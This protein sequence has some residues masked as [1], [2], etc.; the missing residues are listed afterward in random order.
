MATINAVLHCRLNPIL[1]DVD[2]TSYTIDTEPIYAL[3]IQPNVKAIIPVH[4]FGLAA[5]MGA[6]RDVA[7]DC[8]LRVIEDACEALGATYDGVPVG[9]L[10]DVSCFSFYM[11]HHITAGVGGMAITDDPQYARKMRSLI[12]HGWERKAAPIDMKEFDFDE[13]RKRYHFASIG[14][15]SRPTEFEAAI[16]LPQL[17]DLTINLVIRT[18]NAIHLTTNLTQFKDKLQLPYFPH[19]RI[20]SCMMYPIILRDGDKWELIRHLESNGIET[21]EMLPLTNQPCYKGLFDEDDYP[22][23]KWINEQGFYVGCSQYLTDEH[24]AYV[25]EKIGEYFGRTYQH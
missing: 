10:G 3:G 2:P 6:I 15:S 20:H 14:H 1:A 16:A 17:D 13:I 12:N 9:A 4:V 22:V 25:V 23:A 7:S 24:M 19:D 8:G 18:K 21:R 11:S 5:D